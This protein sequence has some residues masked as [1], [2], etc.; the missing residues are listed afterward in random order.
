MEE[1]I[2]EQ[3]LSELRKSNSLGRLAIRLLIALLIILAASVI[4]RTYRMKKLA[5][6]VPIWTQISNARNDGDYKKEISLVQEL[7]KDNPNDYYLHGYLGSI[8]IQIRDLENAEKHFAKAY[9]LFPLEES[10]EKLEAIRKIR[11]KATF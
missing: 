7:L 8:Y 11:K 10:A 5:P 9:D 1:N 6:H 3:I 2:D 4:F